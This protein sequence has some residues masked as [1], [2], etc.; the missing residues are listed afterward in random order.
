MNVTVEDVNEWEP[1]FRYPHYEFFFNGK[2]NELVGRIEVADGDKNDKI[3]LSLTGINASTFFITPTGELRMRESATNSGVAQ[4]NIVAV[5]N[6]NPPRKATVPVTI[7]FPESGESKGIVSAKGTNG[8]A[9]LLT[10]LGAML[11]M[12]AAVIGLLIAYI[13]KA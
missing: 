11:L 4:L 10:G 8:A 2:P 9:F 12:L 5:D 6:G 1:R 3:V 7:H 13:W